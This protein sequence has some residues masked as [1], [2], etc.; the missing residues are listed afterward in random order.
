MLRNGSCKRRRRV[1]GDEVVLWNKTSRG[2]ENAVY[3]TMV[4][5]A[6][7]KWTAL[8]LMLLQNASFV[9]VMRYS[10]KQQAEASSKQY[11]IGVVVTLQ[12]AFKLVVCVA[13]L[14]LGPGGSVYR[15]LAP[16]MRPRELARIAVP[17][18]CF[19]LQNNI[20]YVA[21][22]N[23]DPLLFQI[24]YQIKT[25]LT[26]LF[27]VALLGKSLN[28]TQWLS[29]LLLMAGIVLVQL[30]DAQTKA[31]Q[32]L[33][34]AA[35]VSPPPPSDAGLGHSSPP[36]TGPLM[37][38]TTSS[39]TRN[40]PL[41]LAAVLVAAVSSAFASVYFERLLKEAPKKRPPP[42]RHSPGQATGAS[43]SSPA[44]MR[45]PA[46]VPQSSFT[47]DGGDGGSG[48]PTTAANAGSLWERN[49]ELSA[50]TVPLNALLAVAQSTGG[51]GGATS[52]GLRTLLTSPLKGFEASTWA[53]V[54]VNG[55]GGLLVAAVIK[56]ADNIWKGFA[57]AG[58][59]V[60][61]GIV[62]PLLDLGPAP[63]LLLLAGGAL[64]IFSILLYA[65]PRA[66][67]WRRAGAALEASSSPN[68]SQVSAR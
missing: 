30:S 33:S 8:T 41:G 23:L 61:T 13:V 57:T 7:A 15:G 38:R 60:L 59:I 14:A 34:R 46:A 5:S 21:L 67:A 32:P 18:V 49:V 28:R 25:L 20:L 19:T 27:S 9:L 56:F 36:S 45:P 11:N 10:R 31:Q 54:V 44:H 26:A 37:S 24:T 55:I 2:A 50:W 63:S 4:A 42:P 64:V 22:S 16:L 65:M 40:V 62:A 66:D 52:D 12:E 29:Q 1:V 48:K 68:R 17:A 51:E 43:S 3:C 35:T 53:I 58:A 47:G 39:T 6:W